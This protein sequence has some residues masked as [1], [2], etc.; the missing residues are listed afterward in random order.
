MT[1]NPP[2]G[3]PFANNLQ[4][5]SPKFYIRLLGGPLPRH[6][7]PGL[8]PRSATLQGANSGPYKTLFTPAQT[9]SPPSHLI[10]RG[11]RGG[12]GGGAGSA[13]GRS[14]KPQQRWAAARVPA[15]SRRAPAEAMRA[16]LPYSLSSDNRC[17]FLARE[18]KRQ[19]GA[20]GRVQG[21]RAQELP[22]AAAPLAPAPAR[23]AG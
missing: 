9:P 18:E 2:R 15:G 4:K 19:E 23:A 12:P 17:A 10:G 3:L 7:T 6:P 21:P 13:P 16:T 11:R 1:G 5:P 8:H 20:A 22:G 14:A